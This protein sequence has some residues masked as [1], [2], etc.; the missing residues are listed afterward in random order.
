M[1]TQPQPASAAPAASV[2]AERHGRVGLLTLN[3]PQ[4]L[5]ALDLQAVRSLDAA[6]RA[7]AADPGIVGV[8]L[9]GASREGRP[10]ALCAGGDLKFF[11]RAALAGD[12][13]LDAFFTEEYALNHL[14][15]RY[16]KPYVALM[17]GI[18]MGG[19]MGIS[20]GA[21]LRVLSERSALAMPEANIGLFPDVGGGWFLARCPGRLGEYLALSGH[22]LH[23]SDAIACGLGDVLVDSADLPGLCERLLGAR[24]ARELH[25]IVA[26]AARA[27]P[28]SPLLQ[29]RE[30]VDRH[31]SRPDLATVVA[32]L[33]ADA[34]AFAQQTLSALGRHS[35]MMMA[36]SLEL[37]RR[38]R[39]MG[40]A[41]E[42]R[43]ER[44]VMH[45][46]FHP[47]GGGHGDALE[48]IRAL[49]IDKDRR[50]RWKPAAVEE[51]GAGA[52]QAYFVSPWAPESHPLA[53]LQD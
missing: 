11:H 25:D 14:I 31:F 52:E 21:A 33:R 15:H 35:P 36:V 12:P 13:E 19:G 22:T 51:I 45:H 17:D 18:V 6:L 7:W 32:S 3:R 53:D 16:P 10:T 27:V 48:G 44:D 30:L 38:A 41:D 28:A 49:V 2:L 1:N 42:L 26:G 43:M 5:N 50:P 23:A 37:V 47:A 20:Q 39:S 4:A 29:Q 34:G 40:L 8:V 9:R 46:C 24:E